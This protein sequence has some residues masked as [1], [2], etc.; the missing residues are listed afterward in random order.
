M[1]EQDHG[2]GFAHVL[3]ADLAARAT[4][5]G[6]GTRW[7]SVEH[8]ATPSDLEP[9]TGWAMGNAGVVREL[10]RFIRICRGGDPA[11]AFGRPDQPAV[12]RAG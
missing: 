6:D 2:A 1:A 8:R 7:S 9:R 4:R 11:Y 12:R 5:D 3:V 10:L